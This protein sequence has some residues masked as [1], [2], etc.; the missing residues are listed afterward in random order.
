[1]KRIF[2]TGGSNG[3]NSSSSLPILITE[4]KGLVVQ[5]FGFALQEEL[6]DYYRLLAIL[7]QELLKDNAI[8]TALSTAPTTA[9]GT[10]SI[11]GY[12]RDGRDRDFQSK[13]TTEGN[14]SN[15]SV[16][17][18]AGLTLLRLRAWMQEPIER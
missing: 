7:E 17:G 16:G 9:A 11:H 2:Q 4:T 15:H 12:D 18:N 13:Q 6:H 8:A 5:A 10:S 1:L 3:S 14:T